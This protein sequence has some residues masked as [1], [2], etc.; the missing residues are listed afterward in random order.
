MKVE[1]VDKAE[2]WFG[3]HGS[4]AVLI[5]RCVPVV[6]SLISVPAGVERMRVWLFLVLTALGSLVWNSAL[7]VAGHQL[8]A[9][10]HLVESSIGVFQWAV[11][12]A[13]VAAVGW[14]VTVKLRARRSTS[15]KVN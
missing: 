15:E 1:D 14:F 10:W 7:I 3:K 11:I 12:A 6:R 9:N 13:A 8:G 2:A 4:K 5:G